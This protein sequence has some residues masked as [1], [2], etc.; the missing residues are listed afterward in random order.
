MEAAFIARVL[1]LIVIGGV[2][3]RQA[4]RHA[5]QKY[6][7]R[8]FQLGAGA[9]FCFAAFNLS[10]STR[11]ELGL[12]QQL[13]GLVGFGLLLAAVVSLMLSLRNAELK[14]DQARIAAEAQAYRQER[15]RAIEEKHAQRTDD[16]RS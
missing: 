12:L 11:A 10:L 15:E 9:L 8:A 16:T 14:Q 1:I 5:D 3:L 13:L 6:R 7:K 2:L 4:A